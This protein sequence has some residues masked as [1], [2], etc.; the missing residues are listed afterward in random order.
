MCIRDSKKTRAKSTYKKQFSEEKSTSLW[1]KEKYPFYSEKKREFFLAQKRR[2]ISEQIDMAQNLSSRTL[3]VIGYSGI[4]ESKQRFGR[5]IKSNTLGYEANQYVAIDEVDFDVS[6]S[7]INEEDL[8]DEVEEQQVRGLAQY[9]Q[10]Q[11]PSPEPKQQN[12]Q[13]LKNILN[14]PT[15]TVEKEKSYSFSKI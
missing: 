11:Q 15:G 2:N 9:E 10:Q 6:G 1:N 4:D 5:G 13:S 8:Y 3:D 14:N 12:I 7:Q